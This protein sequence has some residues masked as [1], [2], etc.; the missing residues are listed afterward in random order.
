MSIGLMS[1]TI[2]I[3]LLLVYGTAIFLGFYILI[4]LIT[5]IRRA[6]QALDI[7]IS[8]HNGRGL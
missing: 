7:Y 2:Q 6:T 4:L 8:N 1:A 5:L 3:L